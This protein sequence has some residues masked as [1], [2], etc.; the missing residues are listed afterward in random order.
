MFQLLKIS[1]ALILASVVVSC[2][3]ATDEHGNGFA[4][5]NRLK[6]TSIP[7]EFNPRVE[8]VSLNTQNLEAIKMNIFGFI[9]DVEVAYSAD[10]PEGEGYL[11]L[12]TVSKNGGSFGRIDHRNSGNTLN[13]NSYG[14]YACNIRIKDGA[15][16]SLDGGCY[17]RMQVYLPKGAEIEVYNVGTLISKRFQPMSLSD[18]LTAIDK[19]SFDSDKFP[20]IEDFLNSYVQTGK[21]PSMTCQQLGGVVKDF[22]RTEAKYTALRK[23]HFAVTDRENLSAMIDDVFSYYDRP[24]ARTIVGL[25]N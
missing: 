1:I 12:F 18:F 7:S 19:A 21:K 2:G 23:L 14:S 16:T 20:L 25:P 17:V 4:P 5:K 15:I 8:D 3:G 9:A 13:L 11:R 6:W 22:M 24:K 10:I